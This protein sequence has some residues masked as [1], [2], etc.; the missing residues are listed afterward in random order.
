MRS[1]GSWMSR[2]KFHDSAEAI[3]LKFDTED[4]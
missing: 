4:A 1:R 3:V 2:S